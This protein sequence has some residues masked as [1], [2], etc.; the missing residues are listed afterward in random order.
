MFVRREKGRLVRVGVFDRVLSCCAQ[1]YKKELILVYK[2]N[3]VTYKGKP[4]LE[5]RQ[6]EMMKKKKQ[7][8]VQC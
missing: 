3:L 1:A 6:K 2:N 8:I 4:R 5:T 7:F